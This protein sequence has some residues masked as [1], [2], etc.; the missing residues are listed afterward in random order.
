MTE[1]PVPT[2]WALEVCR[3]CGQKATWPFC[4]HKAQYAGSDRPWYITLHVR[5]TAASARELRE[6]M[7]EA[8]EE[9]R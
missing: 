9:R 2:G 7:A 1:S 5:P 3:T 8:Q 4:E 6:A